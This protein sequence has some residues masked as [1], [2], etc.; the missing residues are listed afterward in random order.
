MFDTV[1]RVTR[2]SH[3]KIE[4]TG[5]TRYIKLEKRLQYDPY[6]AKIIF[7][8]IQP[9]DKM[10]FLFLVIPSTEKSHCMSYAKPFRVFRLLLA[11]VW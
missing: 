3:H 1:V 11:S 9:S 4:D 8:F 5:K 7:Y 10:L 2:R 6:E